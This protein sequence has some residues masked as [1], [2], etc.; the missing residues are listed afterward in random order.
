MTICN[1]AGDASR[2]ATL[3]T[4]NRLSALLL[5]FSAFPNTLT[6]LAEKHQSAMLCL[7]SDLCLEV[8]DALTAEQEV[9]H[10]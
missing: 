5:N 6:E 9:S 4:L 7:M 2:E 8:E 10:V 1:Q 3:L